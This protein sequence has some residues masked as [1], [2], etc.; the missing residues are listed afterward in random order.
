MNSFD[1]EL[2][3][4]VIR[5]LQKGASPTDIMHALIHRKDMVMEMLEFIPV[6]RDAS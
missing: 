6:R 5:W 2:E 3:E 4:L 1:A